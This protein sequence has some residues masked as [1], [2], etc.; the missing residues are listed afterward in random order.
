VR[1][2]N[3]LVTLLALVSMSMFFSLGITFLAA[4][5]LFRAHTKLLLLI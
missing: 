5:L 2:S 4:G 3:P 1:R